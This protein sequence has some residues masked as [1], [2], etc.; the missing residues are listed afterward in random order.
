MERKRGG[1]E[2]MMH[3]GGV[4]IAA[5]KRG[6]DSTETVVVV[7]H[8]RLVRQARGLP[9]QQKRWLLPQV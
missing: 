4:M 6:C 9:Q 7:N 5:Y 3:G 2:L 8:L 1:G